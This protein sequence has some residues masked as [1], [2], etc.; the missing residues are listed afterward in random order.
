MAW[1]SPA[2]ATAGQNV[3]ATW[4]NTYLRDNMNHVRNV[5]LGSEDLG[6][7]WKVSSGR[8]FLLDDSVNVG[9]G[10][11]SIIATSVYGY[12]TLQSGTF[13]GLLVRG[14]SDNAG[15]VG[16]NLA[17]AV[18]DATPTVPAVQITAQK[19]NGT[20]LQAMGSTEMGIGMTVGGG[21]VVG[22]YG[23]G[24]MAI[25]GG[26][27]VGYALT[28]PTAG[29]LSVGASTFNLDYLAG[30]PTIYFDQ[31]SGHYIQVA[32]NIMNFGI[33]SSI[34]G[35]IQAG[36]F[37]LISGSAATPSLAF[38]SGT[39]T[40]L[41]YNSGLGLVAAGTERLRI[42]DDGDIQWGVALVAL[43]G[44]AAPTLGTIGGSGPGTAAQNSWMRVR[45]NGGNA[46]WVPVWK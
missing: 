26:L 18:G 13:G 15:G 20:T 32:S 7:S 37:R 27:A 33:S 10:M 12:L 44:G 28:N 39:T 45:D 46:F 1:T 23:S 31:G 22:I 36:G 5:V 41:I 3:S 25:T 19:K 9:H 30:S 43:G 35:T 40:G 21:Y 4:L 2:T 17:G 16:L 14:L 34:V 8:A 42:R 29:K 11:T 38:I 6:A 24:G